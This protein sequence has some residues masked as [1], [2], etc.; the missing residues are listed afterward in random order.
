MS[1]AV[2]LQDIYNIFQRSQAEADRRFAELT[3]Q[4]AQSRTEADRRFAELTAQLAHEMA[5][6]RAEADRRAVEA[7]RRAAEVD[8]RAAEAEAR[9]ARAEAIAAQANQ[10]VNALSSRW[11]AF[12]ENLV[13]P[14]ALR[15]FQ[16][17]GFAVQEVY[18]RVKSERGS[19]NLEI[20]I[21]VV[22]DTVAVA[23]EVK[24]RLTQRNLRQFLKN[25][26]RFKTAFPHYA[27]YQL[28]GAVAAIEMDGDVDRYAINQGLFLIQQSGESVKI[29]NT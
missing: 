29:S 27:D 23:I 11:G 17:Q 15:L 14:A 18:Q 8:R 16:G 21:L 25:L 13:A 9:L 10:A 7:D 4:L 6:S 28:Y 3:A 2:T 26:D 20:D 1:N 5:Q 24:S 19:Q 22:D 12:V